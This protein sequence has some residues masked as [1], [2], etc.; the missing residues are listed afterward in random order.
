MVD[1][2]KL[3]KD[4]DDDIELTE[5]LGESPEF[6]LRCKV[7]I[8]ELAA[9]RDALKAEIGA[10][11]DSAGCEFTS[12]LHVRLRFAEAERSILRTK[13]DSLLY[14]NESLKSELEAARKQEP[15]DIFDADGKKIYSRMTYAQQPLKG[16]END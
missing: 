9:E 1:L 13:L 8:R 3:L 10:L 5:I 6:N 4:I 11:R 12:D 7:A 16:G 2:A 15:V 14:E